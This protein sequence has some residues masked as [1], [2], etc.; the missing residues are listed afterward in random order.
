MS[1]F[2]DLF[3]IQIIGLLRNRKFSGD[4]D[5]RIESM[6]AHLQFAEGT[7]INIYYKDLTITDALDKILWA[8]QGEV[9]LIPKTYT[10]SD[11]DYI[12][13]MDQSII[14]YSPPMPDRCPFMENISLEKS[15][16]IL[17][18]KSIFMEIGQLIYNNVRSGVSSDITQIKKAVS[19]PELWN[20]LF[21]LMG[22]GE[23]MG[24]YGQ[25]LSV[26]L[27][28]IQSLIISNLQKILG[29]RVAELYQER[30]SQ[31]MD[32]QW[33]NFPKHKNY[34]RVYGAYD[35][36]YGTAPYRAWAMLL[37]QTIT[38]TVSTA[39]GHSCYKKALAL[40]K[41]EEVNLLQQLLDQKE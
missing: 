23:I 2:E 4:C 34:D 8:H 13:D 12:S 25:N 15:K 22:S 26:F 6:P 19:H 18:E 27:L 36:I 11:W 32:E 38:K 39:M 24:D 3:I 14:K 10:V 31:E 33:P 9:N 5:I 41:P 35:R 17:Q 30:L 20:G 21:H 37:N 40:L 1:K 16:F 7:L 29:K 28:K